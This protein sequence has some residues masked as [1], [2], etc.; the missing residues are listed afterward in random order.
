MGNPII[1]LV[2]DEPLIRM[3]TAETLE[4][5][6][7]TIEEAA[8]AAEAIAK[9]HQP[10][11]RLDAAIIDVGLPDKSGDV[12]A[13]EMRQTREDFPVVIASGRDRSEFERRFKDDV[14]VRFVG[15]PYTGEELVAALRSLGI[16]TTPV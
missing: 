2:E 14:Q 16:S 7:F 9:L 6:G 11:L 8:N 3:V 1:L 5:A 12:L 15:K 10:D 13:R 4:D